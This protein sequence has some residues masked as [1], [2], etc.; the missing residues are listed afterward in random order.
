VPFEMYL[1]LDGVHGES[2]EPGYDGWLKISSYSFGEGGP[3]AQNTAVHVFS[4]TCALDSTAP[5]LS[6]MLM[7]GTPIRNGKLH[8]F[9]K[10]GSARSVVL[11][12]T[13]T[14]IGVMARFNAPSGGGPV[15]QSVRFNFDKF[16]SEYSTPAAQPS[17]TQPKTP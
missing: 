12:V 17:A 6:R 10:T 11:R 5:V 2:K 15:V 16:T 1:Q 14:N 13:F 3:L 8:V 4:V 9:N 7:D